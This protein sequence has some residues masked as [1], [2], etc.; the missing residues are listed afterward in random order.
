MR[1]RPA[2]LSCPVTR[3]LDSVRRKWLQAAAPD[4]IIR[5]CRSVLSQSVRL[6][7]TCSDLYTYHTVPCRTPAPRQ[8]PSYLSIRMTVFAKCLLSCDGLM[9]ILV[10]NHISTCT[11]LTAH[12][13]PTLGLALQPK[14]MTLCQTN[15]SAWRTSCASV[16]QRNAGQLP[17][18]LL[19]TTLPCVS[20]RQ[21]AQAG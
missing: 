17:L 2:A 3:C 4:I 15:T 9:R 19:P 14:L 5:S 12:T 1:C 7:R 18:F 16:Q 11:E 20:P 13:R 21:G 6:R 10:A 8:M